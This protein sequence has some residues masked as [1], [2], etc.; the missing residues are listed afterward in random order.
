MFPEKISPVLQ[1]LGHLTELALKLSSLAWLLSS[2]RFL[3]IDPSL[4]WI[5]SLS[6][7]PS[8]TPTHG[9]GWVLAGPGV[10]GAG[11][12]WAGSHAGQRGC[13]GTSGEGTKQGPTGSPDQR[14]RCRCWRLET[15]QENKK[16]ETGRAGPGGLGRAG[17]LLCVNRSEW[18]SSAWYTD[19]EELLASTMISA[20]CVCVCVYLCATWS[21]RHSP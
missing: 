20:Q 19:Q 4:N 15:R 17:L 7:L 21:L 11:P 1:H 10:G 8:C 12:M 9:S 5:P 2:D 13:H 3:I 18:E 14:S 16:R 6:P